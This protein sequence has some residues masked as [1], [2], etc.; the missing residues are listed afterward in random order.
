VN[1]LPFIERSN[2]RRGN[3][4]A[5]ALVADLAQALASTLDLNAALNLALARIVD[6]LGAQGGAVFLVDA[7]TNELVCRACAG[8][9]DIHG[10]RIPADRGIVGRAFTS[11]QCQIVRDAATDPDFTGAIDRITGVRTQS[12][13]GTPLM[14]ARGPIGVLQVINK[15]DGALFDESDRD[16]LRALAAPAALAASNAALTRDLLEH[17]RIRRELQLARRMQRSLLPKRR[18]GGF[19]ILAINHPAQEISGDF[20]DFFDLPDGRIGF[21]VG[22]VAGKGLDAAF[23]MVR[24]AS[25]LRF[26]GKEGLSPSVWLARAND[27]LCETVAGGTF[28]CAAVG[29]YDPATKTATWANAGFPPVLVHG[30][31]G[32][33]LFRAEGPPLGIVPGMDFPTQ[34]AMLNDRS[35]YLFSD[36]VTDARDTARNVLGVHGVVDLIVRHVQWRPETRLRRIVGELRRR[37]LGDDTTLLIIEAAA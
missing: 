36:G 3:D 6:V 9:V 33:E 4:N 7:A 17:A 18:R 25:L 1:A 32:S 30:E 27:D 28:V 21:A 13:L 11:G 12:M 8:P 34:Q 16:L 19:P 10:L 5:L 35:L 24:C 15:R 29:Y 22:D 23:L 2:G 20:Y 31:S 37:E 14:T 26:A